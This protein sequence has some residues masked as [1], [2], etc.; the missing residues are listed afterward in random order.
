MEED[1]KKYLDQKEFVEAIAF[2]V[3][4]VLLIGVTIVS[5]DN[6]NKISFVQDQVILLNNDV[7]ALETFNTG[8][9]KYVAANSQAIAF[10][11]GCMTIEDNNVNKTISLICK[12]V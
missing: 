5:A 6:N 3:I 10:L 7:N 11:N 12:K 1:L 9:A 4:G 8:L 2:L